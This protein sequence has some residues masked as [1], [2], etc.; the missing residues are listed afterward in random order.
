[1]TLNF[2][3]FAQNNAPVGLIALIAGIVG[4]V[5]AIV[6]GFG[7]AKLI[8]KNRAIG[9][10]QNA[11]GRLTA[12]L[13]KQI[14]SFEAT[15]PPNAPAAKVYAGYAAIFAKYLEALRSIDASA[16]PP[17]YR[18]GVKACVDNVSQTL[19]FLQKESISPTQTSAIFAT[20]SNPR[21]VVQ[22]RLADLG[23]YATKLDKIAY[24]YINLK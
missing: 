21:E 4:G 8:V 22:N 10:T 1:M 9:K 23:T 11:L 6:A 16:C 12:A 17:D 15:V 3:L 14:E 20:A 13:F 2:T 7:V 19:A 18:S 5:C 24:R